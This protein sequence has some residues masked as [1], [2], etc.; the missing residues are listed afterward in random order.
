VILTAAVS[1]SASDLAVLR[2]GFS[3]RHER[4]EIRGQ[5]TRLYTTSDG[6]AYVD[7]PTEQI[8][9]FEKDETPSP[10]A[11][12]PA[13]AS[14]SATAPPTAPP[15]KPGLNINPS[16]PA[17]SVNDL[18]NHASDQTQI[19]ADLINS[20]IRAES[21]FN[22]RA[23]SPKGARGL[24]QLMPQTANQLGVPNAF[25]PQA[26]VDGGTRYLRWLL[27]HYNYDLPKALAAYNAGPQRVD[28]YHGIPPYYET[29][30]YVAR[31]IKDFNKK[32]LEQKKAEAA[33]TRKAAKT[34]A[35]PSARV[36]QSAQA[37]VT[38][39]SGSAASTR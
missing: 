3:I 29:R 14:A 5:L 39:P 23:V 36:A 32:K 9:H 2:N 1:A 18:V 30:A 7:V 11:P 12:G 6:K 28:K 16:K 20:V 38:P 15:A 17:L 13:P 31:I 26:N 34:A 8:E 4:R 37:E 25:D 27:D 33:A 19:D 24:M 35:K 21:G 10:A 22:T